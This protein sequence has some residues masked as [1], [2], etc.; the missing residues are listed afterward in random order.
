M[1]LAE[2]S[3]ITT[4]CGTAEQAEQLVAD[5]IERRLCACGQIDESVRSCYRWQGTI[6][7][8]TE[9][10]C[11]LK[12]SLAVSPACLQHILEIHPY[13]TPELIVSSVFASP[14][15]AAWVEAEVSPESH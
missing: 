5:L 10:R 11:T 4:T 13:E 9:W 15:Y 3:Q 14:A 7:R 12:T 6:N 2:I 1:R 8:D